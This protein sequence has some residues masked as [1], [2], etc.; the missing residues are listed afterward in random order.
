[1]SMHEAN[2]ADQPLT[3]T[4][5]VP[6]YKVE[7]YLDD[8]VRSIVAQTH[9]HLDVILIDD[10]SP[11]NSGAMCDVWAEKDAR[12]RVVHKQNGGLSSARNA[13]LKLARGQFVTFVDSDDVIAPDMVE[14]LL[15]QAERYR[16]DLVVSDFVDFT[17]EAPV[18][19]SDGDVTKVGGGTEL[20]AEVVCGRI[21]WAACDKLYRITLFDGGLRFTEGVLYED[22]E[23]TPKAFVRAETAVVTPWRL[24]GYRQRSESIMGV[25]ARRVSPDLLRMLGSAIST[26]REAFP[27]GDPTREVL[28][29][30]YV[31]HASK[32]LERMDSRDPSNDDFRREYR[33]FVRRHWKEVSGFHSLS[34][35]YRLGLLASAVS[36]KGFSRLVRV[37]RIIKRTKLGSGL[38]RSA[39]EPPSGNEALSG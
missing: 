10:G 21:N 36:P 4:V 13:G 20:L 2:Q 3:V 28:V 37:V 19:S 25:S 32:E 7:R 26:V 31:L 39:S 24:Y 34:L 6:V 1:M 30:S 17:D 29:T 38:R 33:T 11:D 23:F 16:A 14:L 12:I 18:F 35:P 22:V 8:C 15:A 27:E 9:E 5:I